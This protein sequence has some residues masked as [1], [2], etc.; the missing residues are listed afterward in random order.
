MDSLTT[1]VAAFA[2]PAI[3]LF[4]SQGSFND[5]N[6]KVASVPIVSSTE[7]VNK[8]AILKPGQASVAR[9]PQDVTEEINAYID[10]G[11]KVVQSLPTTV[12]ILTPARSTPAVAV[13]E[14][15]S[16]PKQLVS[17]RRLPAVEDEATIN[18]LPTEAPKLQYDVD[19]AKSGSSS[20]RFASASLKLDS[21][22]E[23]TPEPLAVEPPS[24]SKTLAVETQNKF[25]SSPP[26]FRGEYD[27]VPT[28]AS[29]SESVGVPTP[30]SP[31]RRSVASNKMPRPSTKAIGD[32][33]TPVDIRDVD[34][35]A[36]TVQEIERTR[37]SQATRADKLQAKKAVQLGF[38]LVQRRAHYS[39]RARFTQALRVVA[40]SLDDQTYDTRHSDAL[41]NALAAYE[42]VSDFY[43]HAARPDEDVNLHVVIG[44]HKTPVLQHA[45]SKSLTPRQCVRE[46]MAYAE[47]EFTAALGNEGFA[48]QALYGLGRLEASKETT[49]TTAPQVRANRSLM[50]FQTA[51][52]VDQR[53]F[54]AANELGVL[55]ARYG[56]YENAVQALRLCVAHSPQPTAWRN[57][58]NI[59]KRLGRT[60]E[61]QMAEVEAQRSMAMAPS[62]P[63]VAS[64]PRVQ[65]VDNN[66]FSRM[67]ANA[68][69]QVAQKQPAA[70]APQQQPV[71]KSA[72]KN[73][74]WRFGR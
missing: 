69:M 55:L 29:D 67:N 59:Y 34:V 46:Y 14:T 25:V 20:S 45:E 44:G 31:R 30:A 70:A 9:L 43:P 35:D 62:T 22:A 42:E 65:W 38:E 56:K 16:V 26:S 6:P 74:F 68:N 57:L 47:Q 3:G 61:A 64:Q 23:A 60:A 21:I 48:S 2:L 51:M 36:N 12:Q 40:R 66:T 17:I 73:S 37:V 13:R 7:P 49:S 39:A 33:W 72:G 63:F 54:A 32:D 19:V 11:T 28:L 58:S 5:A 52:I 50:L 71:E 18:R 8:L 53:N 4:F 1:K 41:R 27:A 15:K 24:E 10:Q